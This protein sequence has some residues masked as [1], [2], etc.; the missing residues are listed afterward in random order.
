MPRIYSE[1]RNGQDGQ[2]QILLGKSVSQG[3]A[4]ENDFRSCGDWDCCVHGSY[5]GV[6]IRN[7]NPNPKNLAIRAIRSV[8]VSIAKRKPGKD[9]ISYLIKVKKSGVIT[10][11]TDEYEKKIL[12]R[13]GARSFWRIALE[14]LKKKLSAG[15]P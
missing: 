4:G 1:A 10:P 3:C 8:K 7:P 12:R 15:T 14:V 6:Q 2:R 5:A 13:T 11:L 9:G